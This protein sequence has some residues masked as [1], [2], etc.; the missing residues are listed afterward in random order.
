MSK[1]QRMY[2]TWDSP[3]SAAQIAAGVRLNDVQFDSD[4]ETLVWLEGRGA[5]GVL[6]AQTG[7]QAARDLTDSSV[8]I[9]GRIFYGGGEFT[10]ANGIVYFAG[11][12]NRLYKL[13]LAGGLPTP[14]TPAFGAAASP[15][16]SGDGRWVAYVHT[17]D[18]VDGIALVDTDGKLFPRKLAYGTDFVM[19]PA[20][21]PEGTMIAYI[22]WD[23][24]NMA[25][26][27]TWLRLAH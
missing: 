25:W 16:V 24:P 7:A 1:Q 13:A 2:G 10:V 26:D 18:N 11:T 15:R 21:N 22:A 14:I 20:W 4:G 19:Q 17:A 3:I 8:S 23:Q 9:R 12:G 27:G 5:Q 6:V